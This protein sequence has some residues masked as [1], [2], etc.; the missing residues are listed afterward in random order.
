[1]RAL[2][3]G[4]EL[5]TLIVEAKPEEI[6]AYA[7]GKFVDVSDRQ[8][9]TLV[10]DYVD[11]R[12]FDRERKWHG[13][14]FDK[15]EAVLRTR[16]GCEKRMVVPAKNPPRTIKIPIMDRVVLKSLDIEAPLTMQHREFRLYR[17]Q[18]VPTVPNNF[19]PS[20]YHLILEYEETT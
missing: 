18:R 20:Y 19:D 12:E 13:P 14:D 10:T 5:T 4:Q 11:A 15:A 9:P 6:R 3:I 7:T 17:H 8:Y 2:V 16:C 1:M